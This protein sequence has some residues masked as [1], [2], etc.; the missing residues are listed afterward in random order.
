MQLD[1][2]EFYNAFAPPRATSETKMLFQNKIPFLALEPESAVEAV[3]SSLVKVTP[4]L[5]E[6]P[7]EGM[8]WQADHTVT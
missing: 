5:T 1:F 8:F 2:V 6:R 7:N 4:A 3:V